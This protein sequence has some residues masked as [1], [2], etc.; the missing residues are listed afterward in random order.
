MNTTEAATPGDIF[1][2]LFAAGTRPVLSPQPLSGAARAAVT[3]T[4]V[5]R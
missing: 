3:A 4:E 2:A 5:G 1:A